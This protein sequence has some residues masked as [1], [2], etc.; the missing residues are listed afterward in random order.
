[1]FRNK[2]PVFAERHPRPIYILH[3]V[4]VLLVAIQFSLILVLR[5]L[6]SLEFGQIVLGLHRQFGTLVFITILA[7]I[8]VSLCIKRPKI[9][10][11]LPTWQTLVAKLSHGAMMLVLLAQPLVGFIVAWARGD[12]VSL[13]GLV[14]V[15][16]LIEIDNEL[17]VKFEK[18]HGYLAYALLALI[19]LH[20]GAIIFNRMVRKVSVINTMLPKSPLNR[21]INRIPVI[22]QL[23]ICCGM[24]LSMALTAGVYSAHKYRTFNEMRTQFDQ[25]EVVLLDEMR[26]THLEIAQ[27]KALMAPGAKEGRLVKKSKSLQST[28]EG[29]RSRVSDPDMQKSLG[30]AIAGLSVLATGKIDEDAYLKAYDGM[31]SVVGS[32]AMVVFQ[33]RLDIT[34]VAAKGHDM[35]VLTLAPTVMLSAVIAFLM[36]RSILTALANARATVARIE[37]GITNEAVV[38]KGR[39][40]FAQLMLGILS[41]RQAIEQRNQENAAREAELIRSNAALE[42]QRIIDKAKAEAEEAER[43]RMLRETAETHRKDTMRAMADLFEE[44]VGHFVTGIASAAVEMRASSESMASIAEKNA[45]ESTVVA[46]ASEEASVNVE[47]IAAAGREM[48]ASAESIRHHM[49]RSRQATTQAVKKAQESS[50]KVQSLIDAVQE[51]NAVLQLIDYV[52]AQTNL[53]ALNATIEAARAGE[54]GRGF[55]VVASE[56]KQLATQT[57]KA[58]SQIAEKITHLQAATSES[59]SALAEIAQFITVLDEISTTVSLSVEQQ[60]HATREIAVNVDEASRG[61]RDVAQHIISISD[62]AMSTG[63]SA[64]GVLDAASELAQQSEGLRSRV[65]LF[66]EQVRAA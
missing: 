64:R 17:G 19:A 6:Q 12:S 10:S 18:A 3:W 8:I 56:V 62:G 50:T 49:Q 29:F 55:S 20:L 32:K 27:L 35:I 13:F 23:M 42:Q 52:A 11:T 58:T 48:A 2:T 45:A 40:E 1:M 34:E 60:N 31:D 4:L 15:P 37:E 65:A 36:S 28:L 21:I 47:T 66:L 22:A 7:H 33:H 26:A 16:A 46:A 61:T 30:E 38:V 39:G 57:S 44:E 9:I 59:S 43:E 24:I 14:S 25:N 51:I 5:Q 54:A 63:D 41:M 53:L